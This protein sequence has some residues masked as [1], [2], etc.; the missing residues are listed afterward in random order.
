MAP[1]CRH[2]HILQGREV[3]HGQSL[4]AVCLPQS[5]PLTLA[6]SPVLATPLILRHE[7]KLER[8]GRKHLKLLAGDAAGA[9]IQ[10]MV[11]D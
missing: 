4:A 6:P 11:F 8:H 2:L 7:A 3:G 1:I 10:H 5:R 9:G